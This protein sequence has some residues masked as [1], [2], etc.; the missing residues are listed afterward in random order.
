MTKAQ[1]AV[2]FL[3][4]AALWVTPSEP[5]RRAFSI[6][7]PN[8][9]ES[10]WND[11][12]MGNDKT[13]NPFL[14][15]RPFPE[16]VFYQ[17]MRY[18]QVYAASAFEAIQPPG[19]FLI[20]ILFRPDPRAWGIITNVQVSVSTTQRG[21]DDLSPVFHENIGPDQWVVFPSSRFEVSS[22]GGTSFNFILP[23]R[24]GFWYDPRKGNLLLDVRASGGR[25]VRSLDNDLDAERAEGDAV[26]SI[27]AP[28]VSARQADMVDT[29][30]LIT[31]FTFAPIPNLVVTHEQGRVV[32]RWLGAPN[33][34]SLEVASSPNGPWRAYQGNMSGPEVIIEPR[35]L[36]TAQ[37]FRLHA[38]VVIPGVT[39]GT[40]TQSPE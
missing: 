13:K 22:P 10:A 31:K 11:I 18:Q 16:S 34:F 20:E 32:L 33:F 2:V 21:P 3:M 23:V 24:H 40:Q 38:P 30:G 14:I 7:V 39:P 9:F 36:S 15:G 35:H 17:E 5:M 1:L 19:A 12:K 6:V 25:F 8:G 4:S 28:S 26:S 29:V 27:M 37:Y